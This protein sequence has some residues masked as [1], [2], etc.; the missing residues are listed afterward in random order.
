MT[1]I[2]NRGITSISEVDGAFDDFYYAQRTCRECH[3]LARQSGLLPAEGPLWSLP[4]PDAKRVETTHPV[5]NR[6]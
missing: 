3:L 2:P 5:D 6:H 4:K 1:P